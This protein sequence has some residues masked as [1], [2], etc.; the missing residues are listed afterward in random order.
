M[1]LFPPRNLQAAMH[2]SFSRTVCY[3]LSGPPCCGRGSLISTV[4]PFGFQQASTKNLPLR[5]FAK[6][7][8]HHLL[9]RRGG[10]ARDESNSH[11]G[12][13]SL[14]FFTGLV[15]GPACALHLL[16]F[17]HLWSVN[18]TVSWCAC[19]NRPTGCCLTIAKHIAQH[20]LFLIIHPINISAKKH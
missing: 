16:P 6:N 11:A 14:H 15:W 19:E 7:T 17:L 10:L 2:Y 9:Q 12:A 3:S 8:E 13:A 18:I 5:I 20:I 4:E 1:D